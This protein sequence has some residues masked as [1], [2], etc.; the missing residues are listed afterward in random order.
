MALFSGVKCI[1]IVTNNFTQR[2]LESEEIWTV[3]DRINLNK[4]MECDQK[5]DVSTPKLSNRLNKIKSY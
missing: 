1:K 4:G 5:A 2:F 3:I